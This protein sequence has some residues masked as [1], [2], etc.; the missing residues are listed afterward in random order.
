MAL[1]GIAALWIAFAATHMGL[2]SL[3]WRPR[4]VG[5]LGEKGFQGLYALVSLATFVPLVWV[6]AENK[7]AGPPLWYLGE[8]SGVRWIMYAGM[9]LA[10]V[11]VVAGAMRPSPASVVPGEAKVAGVFRITR[12]PVFMGMGLFG[13]MHLLAA[14]VHAAELVFFGGFVV[15]TLAGCRH[16]DQ[17]KLA[18]GDE[19]FQRFH[20]QTPFLPFTGPEALRGLAESRRASVLGI[21]VAALLR[22][23]HTTLFGGV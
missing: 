19:A 9:A 23:F 21:V 12:H 7:H 16:Q 2:S 14:R 13:L 11:L 3:R 22:A 6:Y 1:V 15:F 20:A 8:L 10:F 18:G 17:R 5:A 4:L